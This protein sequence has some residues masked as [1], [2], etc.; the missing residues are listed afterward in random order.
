MFESLQLRLGGGVRQASGAR[1]AHRSR[2]R[3]R[4]GEVRAALIEADVALPV[5]KDFIEKV[6]PCAVGENV[7]RS[8]SARPAGHQDRALMLVETL[9]EKNEALSL[10]APPRRS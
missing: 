9:G 6:R 10:G 4:P 3:Y 2:C 1:R 8:A 7:I 5:V